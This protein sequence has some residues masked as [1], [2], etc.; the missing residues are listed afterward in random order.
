MDEDSNIKSR[1]LSKSE[2][3]LQNMRDR[4]NI[5]SSSVQRTMFVLLAYSVS[6]GVII[7]QSDALFV[8]TSGGV[9]IPIINVTV[10]LNAFLLA[11]PIGMVAITSYLH[12]FFAKL[13]QISGLDE[14]EIL[15]ALFNFKDR[16]PKIL[17]F[18]IFYLIPVISMIGFSWKS[19]VTRWR[20]LMFFAAIVMTSV[21][22]LLCL[23][24]ILKHQLKF[25]WCA[26]A[27]FIAITGLGCAIYFT[28]AAPD[29][30]SR[31]LNLART[32]LAGTNWP[33]ARLTEADLKNTD[34]SKSHL[35]YAK[36]NNAQMYAIDLHDTDL[37][38]ADLTGANLVKADLIEADLREAILKNAVLRDAKLTK[39]N[40]NNAKLV[41]ADLWRADLRDANLAGAD[42]SNATLNM[43]NL[44][45]ADLGKAVLNNATMNFVDL[46]EVN[47]LTADQLCEVNP[48]I[49]IKLGLE[50]KK[51]LL[52]KCDKFLDGPVKKE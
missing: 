39:A 10:S 11:G 9:Q 17:T 15:P 32:Q 43:T 12:I 41:E 48:P 16:L 19:A 36:L 21:M 20:Y 4:H 26:I 37:F 2:E 31:H 28:I 22:I 14:Y 23:K 34:L 52:K 5:L 46:R 44:A 7:A 33:H 45:G 6:C 30:F 49:E 51:Q 35:R 3:Q 13:N 42:L 38:H 27:F 50:L 8:R 40:L 29:Y 47:G 25:A 1:E 18:L 24:S